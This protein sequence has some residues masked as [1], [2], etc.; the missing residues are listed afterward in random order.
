MPPVSAPNPLSV[1][2]ILL[3]S[4]LKPLDDTR[5]FEKFGRTLA[6]R[7]GLHIHVAGRAAP[8]PASTSPNLHTHALL[9]GSRLSWDRL[10]AQGRYWRLLGQL[11]PQLVFVHAPELLPLTL[12]WQALGR[13]RR[14]VY[15]VRENYA[16]NIRT[17][18]VYAGWLRGLLAKL[19]R[20]LETLAARRASA[21]VLAERSYADELPFA[22]PA[23]T[24]LLENKYQPQPLETPAAAGRPLPGPGQP[25]RLL[26][27]GTIS[28][29]NGVFEAVAFARALRVQWPEAQLTI[30]GFCQQPEVL[31]ELQALVANDACIT[32]VG[33]AQPVPHAQI[34]AEIR[35]S[36]VGL[37]PY[38]PHISSA[39]CMPTKLFEY[40]AHGLPVLTQPNPLWADTIESFQA[41]LAVSFDPPYDIA[42]VVARLRAGRF[43]PHGTPP[44][45]FW[46]SGAIKLWQVV[47]SIR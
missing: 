1:R 31:A 23:R 33:G 3:A 43:Y 4:V 9:S 25:L 14:F 42:A 6:E 35:Q 19:V 38:R 39:R 17:Q 37:L 26:Y 15:D 10:R 2:T 41:G 27:S 32:L 16:L 45:A 21:I 28:R 24:V 44:E 34:V 8:P 40:L 46:A 13:Q 7:P 18:A 11:Q 5:M 30:V 47:D 36:H 20:G 29:L 22:E 12:L